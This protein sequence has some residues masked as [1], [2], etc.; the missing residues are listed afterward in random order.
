MSKARKLPAHVF[1]FLQ[2]TARLGA[3]LYR[4]TQRTIENW[5]KKNAPAMATRLLHLW[6]RKYIDIDE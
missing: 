4:I 5:D 2:A 6:D 1:C 3:D